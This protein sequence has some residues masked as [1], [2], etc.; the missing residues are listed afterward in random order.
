M[1]AASEEAR[2][3]EVR[4]CGICKADKE[5]VGVENM[6]QIEKLMAFFLFLRSF[7][8]IGRIFKIIL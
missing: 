6:S 8:L 5:V 7:I 1:T 2:R 3:R 4:Y